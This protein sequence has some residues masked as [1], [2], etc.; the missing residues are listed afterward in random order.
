MCISLIRDQRWRYLTMPKGVRASTFILEFAQR[1]HQICRILRSRRIVFSHHETWNRQVIRFCWGAN[2]VTYISLF[3]AFGL[4]NLNPV[5]FFVLSTGSWRMSSAQFLTMP[6]TLSH[7]KN[8]RS[9]C[10]FRSQHAA[11]SV[12]LAGIHTSGLP[13]VL[14][15]GVYAWAGDTNNIPKKGVLNVALILFV[16]CVRL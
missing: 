15:T 5:T 12:L 11:G 4:R 9:R 8:K 1:V 3:V 16:G 10:F 7:C 6:G 2:R 13:T 14:F